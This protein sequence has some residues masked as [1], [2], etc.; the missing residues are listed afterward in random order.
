MLARPGRSGDNDIDAIRVTAQPISKE[1]RLMPGD[2]SFACGPG[3]SLEPII[4]D[5]VFVGFGGRDQRAVEAHVAEMARAGIEAPSHTP[6]LYPVAPH[7]L[8]QAPRMTVYGHDTVPEVEFALFTW[9]GRDYVTVGND[10]SDIEVERLLSAEKAKN[11]CPKAVAG[12]AWALSDCID[13]WDRLRLRLTC[14]GTIM[15]EDG[16]D[17]L[18][19][20]EALLDLVA[21]AT[22]RPAEGRMIFSG[23][24]ASPGTFPPGP[25][26]IDIRLEDPVGGRMIRHVF[27]VEMLSPLRA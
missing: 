16:V 15:Q 8:T 22:K 1:T 2:L 21:S 10:Q 11:L 20:P 26:D 17:G 27:R 12:E 7:L 24:I 6:C 4:R 23:T 19:R 3:A 13:A 25:H 14:N 9:R 5:L 18:M